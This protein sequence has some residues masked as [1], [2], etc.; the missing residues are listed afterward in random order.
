MT[1]VRL[2][3]CSARSAALL[4]ALMM[5]LPL[6]TPCRCHGAMAAAQSRDDS[7]LTASSCGRH[8]PPG[9][10]TCCRDKLAGTHSLRGGYS[11]GDCVGR[12]GSSGTCDCSGCQRGVGD[13]PITPFMPARTIS[14]HG[15]LA[16]LP[17]LSVAA[18]EVR[19]QQG[20]AGWCL[21]R[22]GPMP[23]RLQSLFCVWII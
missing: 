7:T 11:H 1:S 5:I 14:S 23:P 19:S 20:L 2:L 13:S 12:I 6:A 8:L 10:P 16:L 21:A 3:T 9:S 15:P 18:N 22:G 4:A 17:F